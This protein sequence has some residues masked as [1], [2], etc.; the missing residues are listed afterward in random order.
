M[1]WLSELA[2]RLMM[3]WRRDRFNRDLEEE[4]RLH[5]EQREREQ[6]EKGIAPDEAYYAAQRQF[7]NTLLLK[8]RSRDMWGWNSL[9]NLIQDVRY[10]ARML[11]KNPGFTAVAVIAL[12]LGIGAN[13]AIFSVVNAVLLRPLPYKD[14]ERLVV[15][16]H[17]GSGP[18]AP[19]N[20]LDWRRQNHVFD[21]MGAAEYWTPN[22][23]AVERPEHIWALHVTS[24]IFPVLGVQPLLGRTFL[25]DEDQPGKE[26]EVVL[27]YGSWQQRFGGDAK[28]IGR[29]VTLDGEAYTIVGV[30]PRDFKFA[31]FWATKAELWTPL[32][33]GDRATS[34]S[35]N[36]LRI[37]ARLKPGITLVA[38]RAEMATITARLEKE[39]PGTNRGV[40]V[41][42][43][44]EKVVGNV[45]PALLV[46]LG[47]VGFVLLIACANVA[48]MLLARAA[49]RQKE[50]AVRIA[51]GAGRSR[52]IYQF[53]T[54]SILLASLGGGAGLLLALWGIRVLVALSPAGIPRVETVG[55]DGT[56]LAFMLGVSI[57]TGIAFGLF[58][59]WQAS[60]VSLNDSLKEGGRGSTEGIRRNRLRSLLVAS[61]FALAMILLIGA[62]LMIRSL[63]ALQ[64]IDPG[65]NPHGVLTMVVSVTGSKAAEPSRRATFFRQLLERVRSLPGV[66][67]AS[68]INHLPLAG[69][70]WTKPLLIEGRPI[71]RPGDAP[72]AVYRAVLPGYFNTMNIPILR[73]RD[74][75]E[76]DHL[77][78]PGVVVINEALANQTW[79]GEN[80][81][82]K[83]LALLDS[84]P[85][86]QWLTVVGVTKNARQIY[87]AEPPD[88]EIYLPLPQ[89]PDYLESPQSH[90]SYLTLV[91]R[92][93]G[94]PA[95][96]APAIES[97]VSAL[98]KEVTVSQV[99]TMEQ[100]VVDATA[101]PRFYLLLLGTFAAVALILAAVG[102]Y[103]VMSYSVSRRTH[104]MGV[105]MALGAE[106][107]DVLRLVVGQGMVLA[108]VG[109][110]VGLLGAL[111][112]TRLMA[113]LLYGV[114][115]HDPTT[116]L[117]V[118]IVLCLVALAANYL[119]A[120]RA[121]KIDPMVALRYE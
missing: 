98:D 16:L 27:S 114:Q 113:S 70:L 13:T 77:N 44:K 37:F 93:S 24:D 53:L 96:L 76:S 67:S 20:F 3:L 95:S 38:A 19:A 69:D 73:G 17:W 89:S 41:G 29:S 42:S 107:G 4:M 97:E 60:T 51:L 39:Y 99:Q 101:Q 1:K 43:L 49:V 65:F 100:V 23:T 86:P 40:E 9:E 106:G 56:V 72:E 88:I 91:V 10:G 121:T 111:G 61:E 109:A 68:A 22:L 50:V 26:H 2:R 117:V 7:G 102:I 103:G 81:I 74:V 84:L 47:A 112:L 25:P 66:K 71:P 21:G 94:D 33:L 18:V 30:M 110:G 35:G 108:L 48:H 64:S 119:P 90:F 75:A 6:I 54:E 83:R 14:A 15:I 87:W 57:L 59:A 12:A 62:G 79:P 120:R 85:N 55:L 32:A 80:P 78:S 82:G 58:P 28:V 36:S 11:I 105:R 46:L 5:L 8:E 63:Y 104:E 118:T 115:P 34:R 52:V 92:A 116:F 31:P 45:R